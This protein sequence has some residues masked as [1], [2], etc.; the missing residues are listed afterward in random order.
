MEFVGDTTFTL[1]GGHPRLVDKL[2]RMAVAFSV[3]PI[4]YLG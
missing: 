1:L 4:Y 3:S 2:L